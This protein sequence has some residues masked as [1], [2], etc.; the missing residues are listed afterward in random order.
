MSHRATRKTIAGTTVLLLAALAVST[1]GCL[2]EES[3]EIFGEESDE[4]SGSEEESDAEEGE[5]LAE[6]SQ[7]SC[8]EWLVV[9]TGIGDCCMCHED[10]RRCEAVCHCSTKCPT[11]TGPIITASES[12]H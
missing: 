5:A 1:G 2:G 11:E 7:A 4:E 8:T 6:G 3:E 9:W 12:A 10:H